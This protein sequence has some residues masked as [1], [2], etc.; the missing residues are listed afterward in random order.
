MQERPI[1]E[2]P[3]AWYKNIVEKTGEHFKVK[4]VGEKKDEH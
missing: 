1:Q 4:P 3:R 2:R